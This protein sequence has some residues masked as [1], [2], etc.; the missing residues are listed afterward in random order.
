MSWFRSTKFRQQKGRHVQQIVFKK[1]ASICNISLQKQ[2]PTDD[3]IPP[4]CCGNDKAIVA[5]RIYADELIAQ[6]VDSKSNDGLKWRTL[7]RPCNGDLFGRWGDALVDFTKQV[8]A[9]VQSR[10]VRP[11][12]VSFPIRAS[13]EGAWDSTRFTSLICGKQNRRLFFEA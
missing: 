7:C 12:R 6:Q 3:H 10:V 11:Q 13:S 2:N 4:Q 1:D 8:E 9:F 5:R